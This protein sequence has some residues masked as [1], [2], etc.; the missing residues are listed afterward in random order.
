M[1][2]V[3]CCGAEPYCLSTLGG[4]FLPTLSPRRSQ[5][6][7]LLPEFP[8]YHRNVRS[9]PGPSPK[10]SNG[11]RQ[12]PQ[13]PVGGSGE[14]LPEKRNKCRVLTPLLPCPC[15]SWSSV[16]GWDYTRDLG[17]WNLAGEGG[18]GGH[19]HHLKL[20]W[21]LLKDSALNFLQSFLAPNPG[22]SLVLM[23]TSSPHHVFRDW[24]M[25]DSFGWAAL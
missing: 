20:F 19:H 1:E 15:L 13:L 18:L 5:V 14:T 11:L 8:L 24:S 2:P 4:P 23:T 3:S 9:L 21:R 22:R 16:A 7:V 12:P 17:K 10:P 25:L 6:L